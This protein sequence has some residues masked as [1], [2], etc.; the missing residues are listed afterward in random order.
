MEQK[1][2]ADELR[3]LAEKLISLAD[4][5]TEKTHGRQKDSGR[6]VQGRPHGKDQRTADS[7]RR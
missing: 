1:Q 7:A 4:G 6:K 5:L 3:T 2:L